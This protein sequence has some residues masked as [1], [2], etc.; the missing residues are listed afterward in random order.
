MWTHLRLLFCR[1][2]WHLRCCR[3]AAGQVF[4]AAT[5]VALVRSWLQRA[6]RLDW[7]RVTTDLSGASA[8]L[9][10]WCAV[11]TRFDL[12]QADFEERWC[13]GGVLAHVSLDAAGLAALCVHVP[14]MPDT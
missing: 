3:A 6:I 2:V 12:S 10:T 4:T 11:H 5:V 8:S 13:L 14:L 7:L 9:P 1:A